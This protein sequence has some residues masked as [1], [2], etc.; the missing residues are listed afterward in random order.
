M[1]KELLSRYSWVSLSGLIV[2]LACS[3]SGLALA[4]DAMA[5][6]DDAAVDGLVWGGVVGVGVGGILVGLILARWVD[7][8]GLLVPWVI[9][10][11]VMIGAPLLAS[12]ALNGETRAAAVPVAGM[13]VLSGGL[14]WLTQWACGASRRTR[15]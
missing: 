15:G 13:I 12:A 8:P 6:R 9:S 3:L 10:P 2:A 7:R 5:K 14:A 4:G 11:G 1:T